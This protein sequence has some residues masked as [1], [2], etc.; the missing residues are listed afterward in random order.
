[1]IWVPPEHLKLIVD[2][3]FFRTMWND[4]SLVEFLETK[5]S[6]ILA[7]LQKIAVHHSYKKGL[8][9]ILEAKPPEDVS[10]AI[11]KQLTQKMTE[12]EEVKMFWKVITSEKKYREQLANVRASASF[13]SNVLKIRGKRF[14]E[15]I[16]DVAQRDIKKV[17]LGNDGEDI[18][19]PSR[20]TQVEKIE[21]EKVE[22][23]EE[24]IAFWAGNDK[25]TNNQKLDL[26]STPHKPI[27]T[28]YK[29]GIIS[30]KVIPGF[31]SL[32]STLNIRYPEIANE[33]ETHEEEQR[34]LTSLGTTLKVW[35]RKTL[36][37]ST[38]EELYGYLREQLQGENITDRDKKLYEIFELTLKEFYLMIKYN[39]KYALM[40]YNSERK[41]LVERVSTPFKLSNMCLG[42]LRRTGLKRKLCQQR[43]QSS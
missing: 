20:I 35:L 6:Q 40:R 2:N 18:S 4:W 38:P 13:E 11:M 19:T 5:K 42:L 41:F 9:L 36:S 31:K 27:L 30:S 16:N 14:A 29:F 8:Q 34:I 15:E 25:Q 32:K 37:A 22:F 33:I 39:P 7:G 1:M 12:S 17:E 10:F 21:N 28:S 43:Q 23:D 3:Y 26:F 24:Q